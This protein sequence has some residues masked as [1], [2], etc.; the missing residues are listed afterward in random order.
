MTL[1]NF[2]CVKQAREATAVFVTNK[3]L[4]KSKILPLFHKFIQFLGNNMQLFHARSIHP[5]FLQHF[6]FVTNLIESIAYQLEYFFKS[7]CDEW[8]MQ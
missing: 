7:V 5:N 1:V 6:H 4:K 2:F 8:P 3:L